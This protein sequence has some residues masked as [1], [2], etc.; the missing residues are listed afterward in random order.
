MFPRPIAGFGLAHR[1]AGAVHAEIQGRGAGGLGFDR[2][3]FVVVDGAAER[4]GVAFHGLGVD[5]QSGQFAQQFARLGEADPRRRQAGHA[6]GRRRER[7]IVHAQC[8]VAR[9]E[10]LVAA[11][12]VIPGA[13]QFELA[14]RGGEGLPAAPSIAG[15]RATGAGQVGTPL[16]RTVGVE[17]PAER[18]A[19]DAEGQPPGCGLDG[20]EVDPVERTRADQPLDLGRRLRRDRGLDRPLFAGS[21]GCL[22]SRRC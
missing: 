15:G 19:H 14:E 22:A 21:A 20:L 9:R 2:E 6:Q 12:A 8:P 17:T 10:A 7:P 16:V 18:S 13:L 1:H 4:L 11:L 5:L 3:P